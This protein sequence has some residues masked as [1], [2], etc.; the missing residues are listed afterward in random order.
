MQVTIEVSDQLAVQAQAL[1]LTPGE[2]LRSL[3]DEAALT[4]PVP[5]PPAEP[6]MNIKEFIRAMSANSENI[7]Q[8]PD[9]A[10]T[11]ESFYQDHD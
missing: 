11:R 6:K 1:G 10:L 4:A 8:I 2:Y 9:A 5:I 3:I 7:P